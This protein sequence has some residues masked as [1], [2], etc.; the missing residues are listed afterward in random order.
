MAGDFRE[1]LD[2]SPGGVAG[3]FV[4]VVEGMSRHSMIRSSVQGPVRTAS[5]AF[6]FNSSAHLLRIGQERATSLSELLAALRTR[7]D[8]SIFHH[9]FR[10]LEDHHFIRQGFPRALSPW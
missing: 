6:Y 1:S 10:T 5:K 7:P 8:D 3:V 4:A 2:P 9:T